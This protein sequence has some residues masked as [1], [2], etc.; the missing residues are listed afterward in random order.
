MGPRINATVVRRAGGLIV[1]AATARGL[2]LLSRRS[3][4]GDGDVARELPGDELIDTPQLVVDRATTIQA[5][6]AEVWPWVLALGKGR[7]Q[8]YMPATLERLVVWPR[9]KRAATRISPEWLSLKVGDFVPDW[10]PGDPQF[11]VESIDPPHALVYLSRRD[12]TRGWA[13]PA[14][15]ADPGAMAF[16]WA[17]IL[18]DAGAGRS[19]LHVRL[20]GRL[21]PRGPLRPLMLVL[22]GLLD[23]LTIVLMFAGLRQRVEAR[24]R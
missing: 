24:R 9:S 23:Y 10:G 8:W 11:R 15:E 5:P 17:L 12:R 1:A 20:R 19:R 13:W 3:G 6:L 16:S 7:A 22:G 4:V 18:D 2:E 14:D 21:G